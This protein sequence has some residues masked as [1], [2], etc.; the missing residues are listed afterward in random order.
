MMTEHV[1]VRELVMGVL[2]SV[3]RDGEYSHI[4]LKNTLDKYQ[5]LSKQERSFITRVCQGTLEHMIWIDY[6]INQFSTV[7]INKMKP[8]IRTILRSSVYEL[9]FM[10]SVPVSA[11][12]NEAVKL[13]A[14]K[15]FQ[16]LKG[17]VN[18]VLRNISRSL[19]QIKLPDPATEYRDYLS[20][21]YSMPEWIV[22]QLLE[23]YEKERTE[24]ILAA[25]LA[26]T[27]TCIRVNEARISREELKKR[28]GLE[29]VTV[30]EDPEFPQGLFLSDY[31]HL[32]GLKSFQ[33]GLFY[34]QDVSSMQVA[35]SS[36]V[37]EGDYVLDVC[38]APGGK[39]IHMAEL[40][41]GTGM[42]EA[43]DLT[44]YKVGL[45]QENIFRCGL[46]N[47]RTAQADARVLR[48][49]DVGT[50]DIVIADLP[51]SGLGV[52][53]KKADIKYK[54]TPEKQKELILLQRDILDVVS[55]YVKAGGTLM[56]STCT[57]NREENEDNVQWFLRSHKDFYLEEA[58]QLLPKAGKQDGFFLARIKKEEHA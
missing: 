24:Q 16:N 40:L 38:A 7:K 34:V 29:G 57:V 49:E 58:R 35:L 33:Q 46:S 50:A 53:G 3:T 31:D 6:C 23:Q 12:V 30:Q 11:T 10:D 8:V 25:F 54:M 47:I 42:V 18:G 14:K 21:R 2:L 41:N 9:K 19:D 5:Y 55:R 28:L 4:A 13:A 37:K 32:E 43:R 27:E 20:V 22:G 39:S 52:I 45:I 36:G 26:D 56:Y 48:Q 44:P 15:G 1:N 17:F 51:C